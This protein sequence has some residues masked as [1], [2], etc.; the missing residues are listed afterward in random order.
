MK[1]SA[2]LMHLRPT[3]WMLSCPELPFKRT[4][5]GILEEFEN[6]WPYHIIPIILETIKGGKY[7]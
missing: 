7:S 5:T 3:C 2:P 1:K 6:A 4:F